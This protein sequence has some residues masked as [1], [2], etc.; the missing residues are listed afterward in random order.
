MTSFA[1]IVVPLVLTLGA[2][3]ADRRDWNPRLAADYLD[4]R[5]K[6]WFA[7]KTASRTGGPCVSCH[8]GVPYLIARPALRRALRE[9]GATSYEDGLRAGLRP[10]TAQRRSRN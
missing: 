3:A 4:Q 10:R 8:T 6:D 1:K 9:S 2:A 5:Q 7:W